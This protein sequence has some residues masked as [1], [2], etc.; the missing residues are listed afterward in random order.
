ML[1]AAQLPCLNLSGLAAH[2]RAISCLR[3]D[4]YNNPI[5]LPVGYRAT[6]VMLQEFSLLA[7][8]ANVD[9]LMERNNRFVSAAKVRITLQILVKQWTMTF[10]CV[11]HLLMLWRTL[12]I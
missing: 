11:L 8:V 2:F 5:K 4:V 9:R 10:C 7:K 1:S 12:I 6:T 3:L